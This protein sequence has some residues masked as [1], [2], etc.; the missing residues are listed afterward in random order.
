MVVLEDV[1]QAVQQ[2]VGQHLPDWITRQRWLTGRSDEQLFAASLSVAPDV[3]RTRQDLLG[4][5]G[6]RTARAALRQSHGMRW[7]L[8][9]D[10]AVASFVAA[11]SASAPGHVI[12]DVL[13]ASLDVERT[14][15]ALGLG[16]VVRDLVARGFPLP[17]ADKGPVTA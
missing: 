11:C 7:E 14:A 5:D 4:D 6:W 3:V 12:V 8:E 2:P 13:A 1:R 15:V 17:P 10:D 9:V 16:P